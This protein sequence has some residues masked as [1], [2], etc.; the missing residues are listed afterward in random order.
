MPTPETDC[1]PCPSCG[2]ELG[3]PIKEAEVERWRGPPSATL[4]CPACG[5]GWVGNEADLARARASW[6]AYEKQVEGENR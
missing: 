5:A 1:P 4:F 3:T 6:A 2:L